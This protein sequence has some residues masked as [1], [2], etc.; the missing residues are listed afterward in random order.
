MSPHIMA[1]FRKVTK[2]R[3]LACNHDVGMYY[4]HF[5]EIAYNYICIK[6][7]Q[8]WLQLLSR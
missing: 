3:N 4:I 2:N 5:T 8:K 1:K 6:D 7:Q